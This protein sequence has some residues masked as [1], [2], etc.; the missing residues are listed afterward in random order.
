M[1]PRLWQRQPGESPADFTAF[2]AYLRLKGRRSHRATAEL[3]G[4]SLGAIRRLS[5]NYHWPGRVA[6]FEARLADATQDAVDGVIKAA[7]TTS[8]SDLEQFRIKEFLL[9]HQIIHIA[10]RWLKLASDPRRHQMSLTRICRLIEMAFKLKCLAV[11]MPFGDEPRRRQRP[12][13]RPGYWTGPSVEEALKKIYGSDSDVASAPPD[14]GGAGN[15]GASVPASR[16]QS[17]ESP[18]P[19]ASGAGGSPQGLPASHSQIAESG[20]GGSPQGLLAS[21]SP[22]EGN[23]PSVPAGDA[24]GP[25]QGPRCDA[26]S[27]WART[28]RRMKP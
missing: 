6:A 21:R 24:G 2:A 23:P 3:T 19:A 1:T 25:P 8:K 16:P 4:R 17:S 27:R 12:E 10:H 5:A 15:G 28:M 22:S 18:P 20:I 26:W 13:D 9:A 7:A 11:G 14:A